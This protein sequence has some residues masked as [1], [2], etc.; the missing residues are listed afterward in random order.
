MQ[1][2]IFALLMVAGIA[3]AADTKITDKVRVDGKNI[4]LPLTCNI[5]FEISKCR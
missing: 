5:L 2:L 1:K 3:Y 4:I